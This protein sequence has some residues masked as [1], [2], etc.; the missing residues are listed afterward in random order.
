MIRPVRCTAPHPQKPGA[1]CNARLA[2]V[3]ERT[4]E[5]RAGGPLGPG[6]VEVKCPRCG[7]RY[8]LRPRT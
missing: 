4:V 8:V 1:M 6:A 7:T 5:T 3:V 2:D